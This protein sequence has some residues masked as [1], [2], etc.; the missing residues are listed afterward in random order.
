M[1]MVWPYYDNHV[2]FT[3]DNKMP[4]TFCSL[5]WLATTTVACI[6][7]DFDLKGTVTTVS[8]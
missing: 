1:P 5:V 6:S 3:Y 2:T 8:L 7:L 4:S